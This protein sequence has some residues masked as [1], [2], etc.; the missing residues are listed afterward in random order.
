MMWDRFDYKAIVCYTGYKDRYM[1]LQ[2]ELER[3]GMMD[4]HPHW[5]FPNPYHQVLAQFLPMSKFNRKR[6]CFNIGLNNYRAIATAYYLGCKNCLVMEDDIRFLKDTSMMTQIINCLPDD[7]DL[8]L[9]D[10]NKPGKMTELEY[11]QIFN[12]AIAPYWY[13]FSNL[14][15]TGC[16]AMSRR[17]MEKYLSVFEES[18]HRSGTLRNPDWYFQKEC[19]GDDKNLYVSLPNVAL[20]VKFPNCH[21]G[22]E[23]EEYYARHEITGSNKNAYSTF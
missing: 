3:V 23:M 22:H 10:N 9:L 1:L 20:Q 13:R 16:Y 19:L 5:D 11:S 4:V 8:A 15:S 6:G 14:R 21:C 12:N 18:A 2:K 17:C 7:F